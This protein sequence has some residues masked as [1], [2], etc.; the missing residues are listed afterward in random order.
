MLTVY[1]HSYEKGTFWNEKFSDATKIVTRRGIV[2]SA[3][4][5]RTVYGKIDCEN[6]Y[7][8]WETIYN[9]H[10][11]LKQQEQIDSILDANNWNKFLS[12]NH[13]P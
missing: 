8:V 1:D 4:E 5:K 2:I 9:N 11:K 10:K 7:E 13:N 12:M 3:T 6:L